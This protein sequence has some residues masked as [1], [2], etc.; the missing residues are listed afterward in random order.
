MP[1]W[2]PPT[3]IEARIRWYEILGALVIVY[4]TMGDSETK[5][6]SKA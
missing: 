4:L 2:E 1:T 6:L 5:R 3:M